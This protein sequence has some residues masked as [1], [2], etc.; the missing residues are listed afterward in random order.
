MTPPV[1]ENSV[2]YSFVK[3]NEDNRAIRERG[4]DIWPLLLDLPEKG[5]TTGHLGKVT[6][7]NPADI[8]HVYESGLSYQDAYGP[9]M[10]R[11]LSHV[12]LK[13]SGFRRILRI[14]WAYDHPVRMRLTSI[15]ELA[16]KG[17]IHV[18]MG[19]VPFS[20]KEPPGDPGQPFAF[21]RSF[22]DYPSATARF[23]IATWE[24]SFVSQRRR[25]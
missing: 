7:D 15:E 8:V 1:M 23:F 24:S 21:E 25:G 16:K 20:R 12:V 3:P 22:S 4:K 2:W 10:R 5:I 6:P 13:P 11:E 19:K 14:A 9:D 18:K 17:K